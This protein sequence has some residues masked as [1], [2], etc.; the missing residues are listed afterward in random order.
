MR[1]KIRVYGTEPYNIDTAPWHA[2]E[3]AIAAEADNVVSEANADH[4]D[5]PTDEAYKE[6]RQRVI[7]E[8]TRA[9]QTEGDTYTDPIGVVWELIPDPKDADYD[10]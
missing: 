2:L 9:L 1:L 3:D 7:R 8:A 4:I 6:L 10:W 5:E